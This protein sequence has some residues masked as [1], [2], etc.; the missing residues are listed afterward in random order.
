M[1]SGRWRRILYRKP[2][3]KARRPGNEV[4]FSSKIRL[5]YNFIYTVKTKDKNRFLRAT[6][7]KCL[8]GCNLIK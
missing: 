3:V 6:L 5:I 4:E 2:D 7:Y 1:I 8:K